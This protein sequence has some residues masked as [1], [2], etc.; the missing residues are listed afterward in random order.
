MITCPSKRSVYKGK[1]Y[2]AFQSLM[3]RSQQPALTG[4]VLPVRGR[5]ARGR[6]RVVFGSGRPEQFGEDGPEC[7]R[8]DLISVHGGM[9]FVA[10][11]HHSI[12]K[13]PVRVGEPAVD[14]QIPDLRPR[15]DR[16]EVGVN[17][18]DL[19]HDRHVVVARKDPHQNDCSVRGLRPHDADY[20]LKTLR[21]IGDGALDAFG[22]QPV[23]HVVGTGQQHDHLRIDAVQFTVFEPPEDVF[24]AIG[25]PSEIRRIP[26]EEILLPV[27]Q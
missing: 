10:V 21:H 13:L 26:A 16:G 3:I 15:R 23:A 22:R 8:P 19:R 2:S 25:T 6:R 20:G 18:V 14:V 24:N 27:L 11:V 17:G 5:I 4:F 12:V 9:Q 7:V 1:V